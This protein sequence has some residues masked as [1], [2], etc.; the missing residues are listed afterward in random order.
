MSGIVRTLVAVLLTAVVSSAAPT[1]GADWYVDNQLGDD[2]FSGR[3][4]RPVDLRSGPLAT[5]R[6]ALKQAHGGDTIHLINTGEPYFESIEIA[7]PRFH[8]AG[9][10]IEGNGAVLSGVYPIPHNAWFPLGNG[11]WK[12]IPR[13]KAHYQL[14][15][16]DKA[17]TESSSQPG[18]GE[19]PVIPAGN[20]CAWQGAIYYHARPE[21]GQA[22]DQLLL[23]LAAKEV[24][25]T[26]HDVNEVTIRNLTVRHFR[27]D[28]VSAHDRA[29]GVVL[30]NVQ[31][32]E[33]GRSGLAV[34]GT[35]QV[36]VRGGELRGNRAAEVWSSELGATRLLG[37]DVTG[38]AAPVNFRIVGGRV[39]VDDREVFEEGD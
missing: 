9:V 38:G 35:S 18:P 23:G 3:A 39:I 33:N 29:R 1:C 11:L 14:V 30:D 31:L 2:L 17:V 32:V 19:L 26:L 13:R 12:V 24:G 37:T 15:L 16:V 6:A 27:L 20:W 4:P 8:A 22:P 21:P 36:E 5:I 25:L 28:G 34:A 7:G 10:T